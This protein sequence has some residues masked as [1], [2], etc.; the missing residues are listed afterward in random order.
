MSINLSTL[1]AT[2]SGSNIATGDYVYIGDPLPWD[3]PYWTPRPIYQ[4]I[5]YYYP[6][7]YATTFPHKCPVC[8][9]KRKL[10]KEFYRDDEERK[11][12]GK[13]ERVLVDCKS[14]NGTGIVWG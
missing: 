4:Y 12:E 2:T 7:P 5:P 1:N 8:E 13:E 11:R 14:C 3:T 9:G 10:I 6:V